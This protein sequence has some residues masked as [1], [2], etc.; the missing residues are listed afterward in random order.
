M[1]TL[2]NYLES[3]GIATCLVSLVAHQSDAG[4][5]PRVLWVP[6]ELGRPL[7]APQHADFQR[8][9]LRRVLH[10]LDAETGPVR[11]DFERDAPLARDNPD[12]VPPSLT[13]AHSVADELAQVAG[14]HA[15]FL[16]T[17][18]RSTAGISGVSL[19]EAARLIDGFESG[20]RPE[21]ATWNMSAMLR[22]RFAADD[23][24]AHYLEA[25]TRGR[26]DASSRQLQTWLWN[27]TLLGRKLKA[28]AEAS[29]DCGDKRRETVGG[30]FLVP[31]DWR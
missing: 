6:F 15:E 24:K 8:D 10:L 31:R 5:P 7:G 16:D 13:A 29:V 3:E 22:Y 30:R 11:E 25:A 9:V 12:W 23:L 17:V 20:Y 19:S 1:S 14:M 27:H 2:A 26:V 21:D 28:F 18:G 4:R